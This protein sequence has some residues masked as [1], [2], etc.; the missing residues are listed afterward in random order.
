MGMCSANS[1]AFSGDRF[2]GV[3]GILSLMLVSISLSV[4]MAVATVLDAE[5]EGPYFLVLPGQPWFMPVFWCS[6]YSVPFHSQRFS[7]W[8]SPY[9]LV[10]S[11]VV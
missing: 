10:L 1:L 7:D 3:K 11:E 6:I 4:K 8:R 5:V 9:L 2:L